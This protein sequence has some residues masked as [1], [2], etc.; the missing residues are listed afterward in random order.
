MPCIRAFF[1]TQTLELFSVNFWAGFR[2]R[3]PKF[4]RASIPTL[5]QTFLEDFSM[6]VEE[7]LAEICPFFLADQ[8]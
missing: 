7:K 2:E 4:V 3:I 6:N 8:E 1:Q 5:F